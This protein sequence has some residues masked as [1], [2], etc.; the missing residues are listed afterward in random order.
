MSNQKT[1]LGKINVEKRALRIE[2]LEEKVRFAVDAYNRAFTK[3]ERGLDSVQD[4]EMVI[5]ALTLQIEEM[6]DYLA[7]AHHNI[8]VICASKSKFPKAIEHFHE[9][10]KFNPN[11]PVAHYNLAL[12]YKKTGETID[13]EKHFREAKQLGFKK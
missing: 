2:D 7:V 13:A 8:G 9:A 5:K 1:E 10:L 11:Y 6:R 3:Y 12:V 4:W